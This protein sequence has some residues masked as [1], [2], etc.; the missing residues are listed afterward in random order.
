[1][2]IQEKENH[3]PTRMFFYSFDLQ[4]NRFSVDIVMKQAANWS[5]VE[6]DLKNDF[7]LCPMFLF[8]C[9]TKTKTNS[10]VLIHSLIVD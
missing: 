10:L 8:I 2:E 5:L 6:I 9:K 7:L 4:N 3:Q 1:M